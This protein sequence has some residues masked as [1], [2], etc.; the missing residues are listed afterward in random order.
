MA[1]GG[2]PRIGNH[3]IDPLSPVRGV[4]GGGL[5]AFTARPLAADAPP[6][7]AVVCRTQHPP[8]LR[9]IERLVMEDDIPHL[10]RPLGQDVVAWDGG[11]ARLIVYPL[12]PGPPLLPRD[13]RRPPL[14]EGDLIQNVVRPIGMVLSTLGDLGIVHRG[15]RPDNLFRP[16]SGGPAMLGEAWALPAA[17]AQPAVVEPPSSALCLPIGRGEGTMGDDL[18]ALGVTLVALATGVWPMAGLDDASATRAKLERGS[19][20]AILAEHRLPG[21][22]VTLVRGLLAEDPDHRP[23]PAELAGWPGSARTR[24]V[25]ARPVRKATRPLPVGPAQPRDIHSL[26]ATL[27]THWAEGVAAVRSGAVAVWIERALGDGQLASRLREAI[28]DETGAVDPLVLDTL[29]C[30]TIA[31]VDPRAPMFWRGTALMPDALG[32]VL[33]EAVLSRGDHPLA[34]GDLEDL[35]DSLAIGGWATAC[36]DRYVDPVALERMSRQYRLIRRSSAMGSGTERLLYQLNPALPCLSPLLGGRMATT[37]P[38]LLRALEAA[39]PALPAGTLPLDRHIAAFIAVHVDGRLD[40]E[41]AAAGESGSVAEA[42][43]SAIGVFAALQRMHRGGAMP[44]LGRVLGDLAAPMARSWH[45]KARRERAVAELSRVAAS[46]DLGSLYGLLA[47]PGLRQR[48]QAGFAAA[49]LSSAEAARAI[50]AVAAGRGRRAAEASR[51]GGGIAQGA[52]LV[53]LALT[54]LSVAGH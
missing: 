14:R 3:A 24:S 50:A 49:A 20:V 2:Q 15:I 47:D 26:A 53:V 12:P 39:A 7:L 41:L 37:L 16:T 52:A 19:L 23:S 30:R 54:L 1:S 35:I 38:A 22:L 36:G 27:G 32:P 9:A 5:N 18:F 29:L 13:E 45:E 33:A 6:G 46:G 40:G 25:S 11:E 34:L 28:E 4:V 10:M 44:A 42:A 43:V 17:F 48:D 21:G 51:I 31:L 8:R